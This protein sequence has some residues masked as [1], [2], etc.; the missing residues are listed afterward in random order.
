MPRSPSKY[1]T[2]LELEIL[3]ILWRRGPS[4]VREVR[5]ELAPRR[6]L[7]Y[8]TVMTMTTIMVDKGYLARRKDGGSFVYRPLVTEKA[9]TRRMLRDLVKRAFDGSAAAMVLN[10]LDAD[11]L[12]P[13]EIEELRD[14]LN[15]RS[16][17][18]EK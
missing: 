17:G 4:R 12:D 5:K 9:T 11:D 13:A 16:K 8:T 14:I 18:G 10:L 7:A 2:E 6:K 1:P 15:R 3:K